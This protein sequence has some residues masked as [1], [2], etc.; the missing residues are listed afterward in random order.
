MRAFIV[1]LLELEIPNL[2]HKLGVFPS[3]SLKLHLNFLDLI[4]RN[5]L[6]DLS[7]FALN[8]L[9]RLLG[10]KIVRPQIDF[11]FGLQSRLVVQVLHCKQSAFLFEALRDLLLGRSLSQLLHH[12]SFLSQK[13]LRRLM[14]LF[15]ALSGLIG[16]SLEVIRLRVLSGLFALALFQFL[17]SVHLSSRSFLLCGFLE[18]LFGLPYVGFVYCLEALLGVSERALLVDLFE[19]RP[20]FALILGKGV[21]FLDFHSSDICLGLSLPIRHEVHPQILVALFH[22]IGTC[23]R[24]WDCGKQ[25]FLGDLAWF[26][27]FPFLSLRRGDLAQ[28]LVLLLSFRLA[29]PQ[30]FELF[31]LLY[32]PHLLLQRSFL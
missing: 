30:Q 27:S 19:G 31:R 15:I 25:F 4:R 13:T 6:L 22:R 2:H 29:L 8:S 14:I 16:H 24:V 3:K 17:F 21:V 7:Y 28:H 20:L 12:E 10:Q 18:L 23:F 5:F 9:L 11:Q 1:L 32:V 26:L